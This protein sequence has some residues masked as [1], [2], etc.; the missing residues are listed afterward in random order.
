MRI[1]TI[2]RTYHLIDTQD[3]NGQRWHL[4]EENEMG[5][6]APGIATNGHIY[7]YTWEDLHY[8]VEHLHEE[9]VIYELD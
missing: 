3:I 7:V 9:Y 8:T 1:D 5:D 6:E 2:E 4:Y